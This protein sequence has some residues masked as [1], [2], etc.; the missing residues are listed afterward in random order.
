MPIHAVSYSSTPTPAANS[1]PFGVGGGSWA[2]MEATGGWL[3]KGYGRIRERATYFHAAPIAGDRADSGPDAA[4]AT[5][6]P[7]PLDRT[8]FG[9]KN[10]SRLRP[11]LHLLRHP[12][13]RQRPL[14]L[15]AQERSRRLAFVPPATHPPQT[16]RFGHGGARGAGGV[17]RKHR[18]E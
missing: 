1:N 16:T 6:A 15:P 10:R 17:H 2:F 8:G 4:T 18:P 5:A 14:G 13:E 7:L 11:P 12:P 3:E 9:R